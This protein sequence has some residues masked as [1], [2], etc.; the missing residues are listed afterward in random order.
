MLATPKGLGMLILRETTWRVEQS[1]DTVARLCDITAGMGNWNYWNK[2]GR[3]LHWIHWSKE[4]KQCGFCQCYCLS[5]DLYHKC[6]VL[7][8]WHTKSCSLGELC[9]LESHYNTKTHLHPQNYPPPRCDHPL[10]SMCSEFSLAYT[11]KSKVREL[12]SDQS[13][14]M[15]D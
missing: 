3:S 9:S 4:V 2:N 6:P 15:Y 13:K 11:F 8:Q 1:G 10:L 5:P 12:F 7:E 14:G